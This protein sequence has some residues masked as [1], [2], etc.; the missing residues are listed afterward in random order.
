MSILTQ[1]DILNKCNAYAWLHGLSTVV[2][3][4]TL[5]TLLTSLSP[6]GNHHSADHV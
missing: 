3:I 2:K 4:V 5:Q 6:P 1:R